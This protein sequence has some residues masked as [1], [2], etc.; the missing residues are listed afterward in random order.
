MKLLLVAEKESLQIA[1]LIGEL[2]RKG[3]SEIETEVAVSEEALIKFFETEPTHVLIVSYTN[4]TTI[5][6]TWQD[7]VTSASTERILRTGWE[8]FQGTDYLRM[9]FDEKQLLAFLD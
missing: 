6:K 4:M 1:G 2:A 5:H 9:P 3:N 8:R 7:L